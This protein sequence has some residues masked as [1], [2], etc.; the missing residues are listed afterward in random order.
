MS[1]WITS[2]IRQA[3]LNRRV[4]LWIGPSY[5]WQPGSSNQERVR[6]EADAALA[7]VPWSVVYSDSPVPI[8]EEAI[9]DIEKTKSQED[10]VVFR[11]P[12]SIARPGQENLPTSQFLPIYYLNGRL[13]ALNKED[14]YGV[15]PQ[16]KRV[17]YR[18]SM[19]LGLQNL[20][21]EDG[22]LILVG[23]NSEQL[24]EAMGEVRDI[25]GHMVPIVVL[26]A[27]PEITNSFSSDKNIV[28]L[29]AGIT[30]FVV[31]LEERGLLIPI[32]QGL[33]AHIIIGNS[34]VR[35]DDILQ[36]PMGRFDESFRVVTAEALITQTQFDSE[37]FDSCMV[38]NETRDASNV[39][40]DRKEWIGYESG[41]FISRDY[42][43][44]NKT[45]SQ[46]VLIK[47]K[48]L[49]ESSSD[50]IQNIT[51]R[52]PTQ[53]EAGTT[54]LLHHVAYSCAKEGFPSFV[55]KQDSS[56][57]SLGQLSSVIT[58]LFHRFRDT[59]RGAAKEIPSLLV[60]DSQHAEIEEV[61][62][63][64]HRLALEGRRC[65]V[66]SAFESASLPHEKQAENDDPIIDKKRVKGIAEQ[67]PQ[68]SAEISEKELLLI[69]D[70]FKKLRESHGLP[71][72]ERT[73]DDWI[74]FQTKSLFKVPGHDSTEQA[75]SLFW[76]ALHYFVTSRDEE[77]KSADGIN[78]S[79]AKRLDNI[80]QDDPL[81]VKTLL[82]ISRFSINNLY[83]DWR[84][85]GRLEGNS[86]SVQVMERAKKLET[87]H[88]VR[89]R[90]EVITGSNLFRLR[91]RVLAHIFL[92]EAIKRRDELVAAGIPESV[93][94]TSVNEISKPL[95]LLVSYLKTL[96][97]SIPGDVQIAE[98]ISEGALRIGSS[99]EPIWNSRNEVL[100]A[101]ES[102]H[103]VIKA[104]SRAINHHYAMALW[105][106]AAYDNKLP[107]EIKKERFR[108]SIE[109]LD[110]SLKI[111]VRTR[112]HDEHQGHIL[113]TRAYAL[114]HWSRSSDD[115]MKNKL[116]S[117]AIDS[118]REAMREL[119]DNK[120][121]AYGLA[122]ALVT[123]CEQ[124]TSAPMKGSKAE[125]V[126][127]ALDLLQGDPAPDFEFNW[128][129]LQ[130]RAIRLIDQSAPA[131]FRAGLREKNEE[132]GYLLEAWTVL[133]GKLSDASE[134]K[135]EEALSHLQAAIDNPSVECGWRTYYLVY[136]L[137]I[138]HATL[139]HDSLKRYE[140]LRTLEGIKDFVIKP[141]ELFDLAVL[142]YQLNKFNDG[143][144]IFR[145]LRA[146]GAFRAF[147]S[148]MQLF[149][150]EIEPPFNP[151]PATLQVK[152][153]DTIYKGWAYILEFGE[154]MP[155]A[156]AHFDP[157]GKL[158]IGQKI[159]CYIRFTASGPKAVPE[160]FY[161]GA[162]N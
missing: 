3:F 2:E 46:H 5:G 122:R 45:L 136:K 119:P 152:R 51:L 66:I 28:S 55:L 131:T 10:K 56:D 41:L 112:E 72:I 155:F 61:L 113:T 107:A 1:D 7:R 50:G 58:D 161:R 47:L 102:I 98:G 44:N 159:R 27:P 160:K 71:L 103:D 20:F 31:Y 93:I 115:A 48:E 29:S 92:N 85:L 68:L 33:S 109:Y 151:R 162:S 105:K 42:K 110:K 60:F 70:H 15:V 100:D 139:K 88:L 54:T 125:M 138:H 137:R 108:K 78:L 140:L 14:A 64:A 145:R 9:V 65:I 149:W 94:P 132:A 96:D 11:R 97:G 12:I 89:F 126:A 73:K 134:D 148:E 111:T 69:Q 106:T 81:C 67:L 84:L 95:W 118:F 21:Q 121:A 158:Q 40:Q 38:L 74:N 39:Y 116:E 4:T 146:T 23:F 133:S 37:F 130:E 143:S 79:I 83:V 144:S 101:L 22:I 43:V 150:S 87:Q 76:V 25:A 53:P 26:D 8:L 123:V 129:S 86:Y 120:Y 99:H 91:H 30:D 147:E 34:R 117:E 63:A 18:S 128:H 52:L 75:E 156:P 19:L 124:S 24:T 35:I 57:I 154:D 135:V 127:E 13:R 16:R 80:F 90:W 32:D 114:W 82:D 142:C 36:G 59:V 141:A 49:K 6:N 104:S 62:E 17:A 157:E 77:W 153:K